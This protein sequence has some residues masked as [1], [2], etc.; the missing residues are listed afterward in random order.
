MQFNGGHGRGAIRVPES[1]L[2]A[3]QVAVEVS[4]TGPAADVAATSDGASGGA[5]A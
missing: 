2:A 1:A 5:P 3:Y 4:A